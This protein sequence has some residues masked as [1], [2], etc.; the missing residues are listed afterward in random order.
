MLVCLVARSGMDCF[1]WAL[2]LVWRVTGSARTFRRPGAH[3]NQSLIGDALQLQLRRYRR[4]MLGLKPHFESACRDP[5]SNHQ[6]T[7]PVNTAEIASREGPQ[8][9]WAAADAALALGT[10]ACS[11]GYG[12]APLRL[13]I[14]LE[15]LPKLD[16]QDLFFFVN[17]CDIFSNLTFTEIQQVGFIKFIS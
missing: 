6:S 10:D 17:F 12:G 3:W 4:R 8:S 9:G 5:R 2:P 16:F 13:L 15:K 11:F 1:A 7:G 14:I